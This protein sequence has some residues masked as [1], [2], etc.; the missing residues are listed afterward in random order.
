[1]SDRK[2]DVACIQG[3]QWKGNGCKFY[4]AKGKRYKLFWMRGEIGR[5]RD[6]RSTEMGGHCC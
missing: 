4:G 6:I 1:L 3:T 2:V 5:C